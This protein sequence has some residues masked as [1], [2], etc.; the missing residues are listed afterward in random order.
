MVLASP[1]EVVTTTLR[2]WAEKRTK[3]LAQCTVSA[4]LSGKGNVPESLALLSTLGQIQWAFF[5]RDK[6]SRPWTAT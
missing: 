5:P 4:A 1:S 3:N 6:E 2:D